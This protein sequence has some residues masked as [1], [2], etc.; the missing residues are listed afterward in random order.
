[1]RLPRRIELH[2][3][4]EVV[5]RWLATPGVPVAVREILVVWLK[6]VIQ[7]INDLSTVPD[8]SHMDKKPLGRR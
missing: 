7:E 5:E 8:R 6:D 4:E 2:C 3:Q 1:M